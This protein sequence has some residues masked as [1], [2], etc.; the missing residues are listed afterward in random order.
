MVQ[1]AFPL[2]ATVVNC[3]EWGYSLPGT[4]IWITSGSAQNDIP[5]KTVVYSPTSGYA[6]SKASL[7]LMYY[8]VVLCQGQP[9]SCGLHIQRIFSQHSISS[10]F[11]VLLQCCRMWIHQVALSTFSSRLAIW[12]IGR[13]CVQRLHSFPRN[14][15]N[16]DQSS[17]P[18][19][20][21]IVRNNRD[22]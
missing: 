11:R 5:L 20:I 19:G 13:M 9:S 7:A 8:F 14:K 18:C 17:C 3:V 2:T 15:C 6:I 16:Q 12:C 4:A 22:P 10:H 21:D 1:S